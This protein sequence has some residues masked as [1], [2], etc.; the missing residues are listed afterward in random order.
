MG[1]RQLV[2]DLLSRGTP[3]EVDPEEFVLLEEVTFS[4]S[5]LTVA[6][7]ES[8]GIEARAAERFT[9]YLGVQNRAEIHVRRRQHAEATAYLD[10]LR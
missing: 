4:D 7:L 2:I 10:S 1:L 9:A 8:E 5:Q 6:S 3:P